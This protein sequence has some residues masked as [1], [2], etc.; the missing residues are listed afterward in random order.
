ML[1]DLK[2]KD[3]IEEAIN[4]KT[5]P[6]NENDK[7]ILT[8]SKETGLRRLVAKGVKKTKSKL[9]SYI[10]LLTANKLFCKKGRSLDI[11]SQASSIES[12]K[13]IRKD[14]VKL[15]FSM[16]LSEIIINFGV[17]K[18]PNSSEVYNLFYNVLAKIASS[19]TKI[20]LYLAIIRFQLKIMEISGFALNFYCCTNCGKL[21]EKEDIFYFSYNQNGIICNNCKITNLSKTMVINRKIVKFLDTLK[22]SEFDENT[23]YD[24][25][26]NEKLCKN[27]FL[28]LYKYIEFYSSRNFKTIQ[29]LEE[30]L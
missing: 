18:D 26:A 19:K 10:E 2:T 16:Y 27:C 4:L 11:I 5:Y 25:M 14:I 30:I 12:F 17:E 15:I 8:Y 22:K 1:N 24:K 13:N 29:T 28:F 7:I 23:Y 21:I 3:Y 6:L 20:E 9:A